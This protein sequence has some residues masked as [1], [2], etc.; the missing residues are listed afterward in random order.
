MKRETITIKN[1]IVCIPQS[2]EI[3]MTQHELADLFGCF[4]AKVSSNIRS[5]FKSGVLQ[6]AD[7]CRL[8]H[9]DKGHCVEMYN[10]EIIIALS[11]RIQSRNAKIFREWIIRKLSKSEIPEMLIMSIKNPILN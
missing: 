5:I 4:V 11:F 2:V 6:K 10:L 9:Y 3:W 1:G 8:H 7:V